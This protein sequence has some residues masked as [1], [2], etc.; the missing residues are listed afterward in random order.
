M[1][2]FS[3]ISKTGI[4][5]ITTVLKV[6]QAYKKFKFWRRNKLKYENIKQCLQEKVNILPTQNLI[7]SHKQP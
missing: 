5:K 7:V 6:I 3:N 1:Y 4:S 2:F